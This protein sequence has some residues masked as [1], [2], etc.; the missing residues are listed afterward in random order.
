MLP[1]KKTVTILRVSQVILGIALLGV[2]SCSSSAPDDN[3]LDDS[4]IYYADQIQQF[5]R[6]KAHR[7]RQKRIEREYIARTRAENL[8]AWLALQYDDREAERLGLTREQIRNANRR[9]SLKTHL[10]E[11]LRINR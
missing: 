4:Q 7:E 1:L 6:L 8:E 5:Q 11:W 10:D 9:R 2:I 3:G